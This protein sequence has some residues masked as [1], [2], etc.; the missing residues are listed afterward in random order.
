[1]SDPYA[2]DAP[3][4]DLL[5]A[6]HDED[7]GLWL[8]YAGR[9][10]RP[11]LEIG[12]GTGRIALALARS[13]HDVVGIDPSSAMLAIARQRADDDA[14]TAEF[15]EGTA[16]TVAL[17][18]SHYGF[19]LVPTDVFLYCRDGEEQLDTLRALAAATH[20]SGQIALD[21]PGPALWL[22]PASD[23]QPVLVYSGMLEDG[24]Q[25]DVWH[26]HED[27]LAMQTRMLRVSYERTAA[28]GIVRRTQSV[29][30]LRYLYRFEVEYLL[31]IAGLSLLGVYGDYDL[32]PLTNESE[33]MIVVARGIDG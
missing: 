21:L 20:F 12:T 32:G 24:S 7:V 15:R 18:P 29:H 6:R 13:G 28:D 4:Y 1:V 3:F 14:L 9:N 11:V 16:T 2:A 17:E 23:A 10:Q 33:R 25:L 31:H 5:H 27:D 19:V 26:L 22:D 8:S 30:R